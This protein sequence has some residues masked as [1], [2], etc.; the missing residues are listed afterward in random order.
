MNAVITCLRKG[1]RFYLTAEGVASDIP[2]R[3]AEY[4]DMTAAALAA[5]RA[6][7]E[8]A[9]AEFP[10]EPFYRLTDGA[11]SSPVQRGGCNEHR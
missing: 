7:T 2:S 6:R 9:W 8:P 4:P 10:W 1:T 11:I 3:A 5:G